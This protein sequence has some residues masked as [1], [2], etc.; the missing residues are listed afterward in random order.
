MK[1]DN[2]ELNAVTAV[3]TTK[4]ARYVAIG[5]TYKVVPKERLRAAGWYVT[6]STLPVTQCA[7]DTWLDTET[8]EV[9]TKTDAKKRGIKL[10]MA[11]SISDKAL[12]IFERIAAC[13]PSEQAFAGYL[14][15]MRN[16][17]GGLV[18]PLND[19]LDRWIAV[20]SPGIRSTNR[21]RK[22][23]QLRSIIE[24][25]KLMVSDTAMAK[26]LMLINPNLTKQEVL[27]ESAK[28]F[29]SRYL[30]IK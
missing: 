24:R 8:G 4:D 11:R 29:D 22:R 30:P 19:V 28:L 18:A 16:H 27:E 2:E 13:P 20:E 10:P 12:D 26:D 3:A 15:N 14:L 5:G 7:P 1:I 9:I 17:R 23:R 25:H 21:A 6:K